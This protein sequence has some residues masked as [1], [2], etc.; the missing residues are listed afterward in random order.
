MR[1]IMRKSSRSLDKT[2]DV[3]LV[4]MYKWLLVPPDISQ[5]DEQHHAD[6]ILN[7]IVQTHKEE[8]LKAKLLYEERKDEVKKGAEDP[9]D[10]VAEK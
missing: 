8:Q 4:E 9:I 3:F 1:N 2:F 7:N 5:I 10:S 6:E